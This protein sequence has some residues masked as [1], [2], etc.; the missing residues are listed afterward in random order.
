MEQQTFL[1]QGRES[2]GGCVPGAE[3]LTVCELLKRCLERPPDEEAWREFVRRYHVAIR[4]N[5][6]KTFRHRVS[7][8]TERRAQFPDDLIED[9]V[10]V[11]Y[12]RLIEEGNRALN[13]FEGAHENSIFGYLGIISMNVVRDHF[14]EAKAQ[15]RPKLSFSL[16]ELIENA[17]EGGILREAVTTI[18][19]KPMSASSSSLTREDVEVELKKSLSRRHRDRDALIFKLRYYEGLTLEEIRKSLGL[20]LSPIGIGSILNRINARLKARLT[21]PFRRP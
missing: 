9:L 19:G 11:V 7:Q 1:G 4:T 3:K 21:R 14:R 6:S 12:V 16:D 20:D 10:Q 8:E 2:D 18:D 5:V 13:R 17:G 15:K